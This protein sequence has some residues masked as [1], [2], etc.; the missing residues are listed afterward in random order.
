MRVI[1]TCLFFIADD[2]G[3]DCGK[4]VFY[5]GLAKLG[6]FDYALAEEH[7]VYRDPGHRYEV[8]AGPR[9]SDGRAAHP[10]PA[11]GRAAAGGVSRAGR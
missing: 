10:G 5:E 11:H 4:R 3:L 9:G 2:T 6:V 8:P 1:G 7:F